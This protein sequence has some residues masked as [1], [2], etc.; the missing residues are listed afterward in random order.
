M[1]LL[2]NSNFT[3]D[4]LIKRVDKLIQSNNY[5]DLKLPNNYFPNPSKTVANILYLR[6][7]DYQQVNLD[8]FYKTNTKLYCQF[9][10]EPFHAYGSSVPLGTFPISAT[11]ISN[12]QNMIPSLQCKLDKFYEMYSSKA[13]FHQFNKY[14]LDDDDFVDTLALT[15]QV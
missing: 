11:M 3:W 7:K 2:Y 10:K 1:L 6:G 13:Y 12:S 14:G 5:I 15:E 4:F 8:C 9:N